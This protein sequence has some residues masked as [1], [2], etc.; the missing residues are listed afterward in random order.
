MSSHPLEGSFVRVDGA[1]INGYSQ[2]SLVTILRMTGTLCENGS[3]GTL[4]LVPRFTV[5][6]L[7]IG[8]S[9]MRHPKHQNKPS[10][11][12]ALQWESRISPVRCDY[13]RDGG[14]SLRDFKQCEYRH[15][16]RLSSAEV[17][18]EDC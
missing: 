12:S 2:R 18:A 5:A 4:N 3:A 1:R 13:D 8:Q 11:A 10:L 7:A 14:T 15:F 9:R 17:S 16:I 6:R